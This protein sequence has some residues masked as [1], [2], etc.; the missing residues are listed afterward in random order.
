ME[1]LHSYIDGRFVPGKREFVDVNPADGSLVATVTEAS[2]E[3]VDAA[4]AAP[5]V[6]SLRGEWGRHGLTPA[7]GSALQGCGGDR[8]AIR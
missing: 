1:L 8:A 3:M 4:V 6:R 2:S 5:P 7:R